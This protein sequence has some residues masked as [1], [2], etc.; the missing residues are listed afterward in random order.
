LRFTLKDEQGNPFLLPN[1]A[2][3]NLEIGV[4]Y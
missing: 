3:V 4:E 1:S 2:V